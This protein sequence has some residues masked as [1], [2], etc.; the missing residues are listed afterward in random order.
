ML[1]LR[2]KTELTRLKDSSP[3]EHP[4]AEAVY[5]AKPEAGMRNVC[6]CCPTTGPM[7]SGME[8]TIMTL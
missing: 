1:L 4:K 5:L 3:V 2:N 6:I 8:L 7:E